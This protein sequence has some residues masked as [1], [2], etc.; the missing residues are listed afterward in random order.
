MSRSRA[1][2]PGRRWLVFAA[3]LAGSVLLALGAG[4]AASRLG[5]GAAPAPVL[6]TVPPGVFARAGITVQGAG[7][8]PYCDAERGAAR[9]RV[10]I[11]V[12]GCAISR[13]D[14]ES[15]LLPAFRGTVAEAALARVSGPPASGLGK[16]RM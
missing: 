15:A 7:Q 9:G 3:A 6:S 2:A 16:D 8:P 4:V 13:E 14:A 5:A 10:S 11:G 12:A 1:S